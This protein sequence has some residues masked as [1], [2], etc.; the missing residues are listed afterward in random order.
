MTYNDYLIKITE[1]VKIRAAN[2]RLSQNEIIYL[3]N[4]V[5]SEIAKEV[6]IQPYPQVVQVKQGDTEYALDTLYTPVDNRVLLRCYSVVNSYGI[7]ITK[8]FTEKEGNVF[9]IKEEVLDFFIREYE[10][11]DI[12]FVREQ[13]PDIEKLDSR[14]QQL[15][16]DVII[17]GILYYTHDQIPEPVSSPGVFQANADH[18][19]KYYNSIAMLKNQLPQV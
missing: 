16:F 18:R 6:N 11:K 17:D 4:N 9:V 3:T 12:V 10:D 13:I 19:S 7:D 2:F 8:Y 1:T 5:F 14:L 15:L